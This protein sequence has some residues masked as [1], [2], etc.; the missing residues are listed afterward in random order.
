MH[1]HVLAVTAPQS[2][3][4]SQRRRAVPQARPRSG[5]VGGFAETEVLGAAPFAGAAGHV[6]LQRHTVALDDLPFLRGLPADACNDAD[7][8]VAEDLRSVPQALGAVDVAAA[9]PAGFD[10]Q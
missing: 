10:L 2:R 3:P 1:V 7:V 4:R 5:D 8:L 6:L 9:N